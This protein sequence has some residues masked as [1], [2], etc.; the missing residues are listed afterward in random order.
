[1]A[2]AVYLLCA[3]T[4]ILCAVLLARSYRRQKSR[5][6]MWSTLCFVGLA[7]N[8]IL[9]FVDLVLTA[10]D[11]DLS[12]VRSGTGLVSVLLLLIGLVWEDR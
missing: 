1:M 8:N 5:L 11:V 3:L 10:E 2:E 12:L 7:I 6:L 4:S 9:L